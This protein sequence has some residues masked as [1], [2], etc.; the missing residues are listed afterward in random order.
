[1]FVRTGYDF[2]AAEILRKRQN[3]N[4]FLTNFFRPTEVSSS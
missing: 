3:P 1:M 4:P 2:V